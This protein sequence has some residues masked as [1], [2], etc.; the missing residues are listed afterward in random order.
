MFLIPVGDGFKESSSRMGHLQTIGSLGGSIS[1][2]PS[3]PAGKI[4]DDMHIK[5]DLDTLRFPGSMQCD[6]CSF[7]TR[8]VLE[9][10]IYTTLESHAQLASELL[11]RKMA[12]VDDLFGSCARDAIRA[13]EAGDVQLLEN[14]RFYAEETMN[15]TAEGHARSYM[16]G[17]YLHYLIFHNDAFSVSHRSHCS[18]VGSVAGALMDREITAIDRG[19]VGDEHPTIFSP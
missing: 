17:S 5:S 14:T 4:L 1:I 3:M 15:C 8:V 7:L 12:Y 19:M 10:R 18:V 6:A 16:S 13:L 11:G 2:R 9:R